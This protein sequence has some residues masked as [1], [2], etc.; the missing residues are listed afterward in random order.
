MIAGPILRALDRV[1]IV[2]LVLM[3]AVAI[4]VP[5]LNLLVPPDAISTTTCDEC[6]RTHRCRGQHE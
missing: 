1:S 2:F 5:V 6:T 3:G 4:L